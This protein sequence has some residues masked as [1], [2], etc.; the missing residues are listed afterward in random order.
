MSQDNMQ[1]LSVP[2]V[3]GPMK[4]IKISQSGATGA[5]QEQEVT[6]T[7]PR[8]DVQDKIESLSESISKRAQVR[9]IQEAATLA[10]FPFLLRDGMKGIMFDEYNQQP[11][12][13]Q[14]LAKVV[15]SDK[16]AEDY[17]ENNQ[18]GL[19]PPVGELQAFPEVDGSMDRVIRIV[20]TKR[21]MIWAVSREMVRFD[22]L[23]MI[24]QYVENLGRAAKL[25]Q[26][27]AVYSVL[28]TTANYTRNSTTGDNDVGANTL[29][30]TF[31]AI[32]INTAYATLATM[33][34]R[35]SGT[36][37]YPMPDTFICSPRLAQAAKQ[38]FLSPA[39]YRLGGATTNDVYGTGGGVGANVFKD[40]I[41]TIIVSP[42][43][44]GGSL[45]YNWIM[46]Q[47][48]RGLVYQEVE[49]FNLLSADANN[50][51]LTEGRFVWDKLRYRADLFFGVGLTNDRW[52]DEG[53]GAFSRN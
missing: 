50:G 52:P 43:M 38:L 26:E 22:R 12:T 49:P 32:V 47:A 33:R 9:S 30:G 24:M 3:S 27:Q 41:S 46:C 14:Q 40:L 15:P 17:V 37:L 34:D 4:I 25:T 20:N 28:Q 2:A 42:F 23:N 11:S 19:L 18:L 1:P 35:K 13:W 8:F 44:G 5:L 6:L 31:S 36:P 29:T 10:T 16:P 21:G 53:M 39:L 48:K 7:A 45:Q 51:D